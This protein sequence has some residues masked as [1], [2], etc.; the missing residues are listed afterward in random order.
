MATLLPIIIVVITYSCFAVGH[1]LKWET[2]AEVNASI[3]DQI[4]KQQPKVEPKTFFVLTYSRIEKE[5]RFPESIAW[6]FPYALRIIY[7]DQTIDS[8]IIHE[9]EP[10][11]KKTTEIHLSYTRGKN[12]N[13]IITP[14][15][16]IGGME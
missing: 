1:S 10:Y 8:K 4:V 2:M 11:K 3:L 7:E 14:V 15:D 12:D 16:E 13:P 6:G 9:V 5:N